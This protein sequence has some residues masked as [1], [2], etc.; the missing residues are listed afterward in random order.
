MN[1]EQLSERLWRFAPAVGNVDRC[2]ARNALTRL[3]S[4]SHSPAMPRFRNYNFSILNSQFSI[5]S[6]S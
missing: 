2:L 5:K 1:P 6:L 4:L 3:T